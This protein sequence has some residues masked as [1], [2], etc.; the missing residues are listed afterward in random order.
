MNLKELYLRQR[1]VR[2]IDIPVK[3]KESF[4]TFMFGKTCAI[5]HKDDGSIQ[6]VYYWRDFSHWYEENKIQI[7]RELKLDELL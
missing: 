4:N 7:V 2:E 1:D 3:W 6:F 5:E